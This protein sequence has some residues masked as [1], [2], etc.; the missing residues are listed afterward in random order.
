M[1]HF[2][3]FSNHIRKDSKEK[4]ECRKSRVTVTFRE[5]SWENTREL[6]EAGAGGVTIDIRHHVLYCILDP[7]LGHS[8]L[9]RLCPPLE[10]WWRHHFIQ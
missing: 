10:N 8:I 4:S 1:Y 3:N 7:C 5:L 2:R 6:T 9:C